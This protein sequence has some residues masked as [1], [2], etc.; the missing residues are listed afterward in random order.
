[1]KTAKQGFNFG[2]LLISSVIAL[3]L[4]SLLAAFTLDVQDDVDDDFTA[5]SLEANAS[6]DGKTGIANVSSQLPNIGKVVGAI[7]ILTLLIGGFGF[8]AQ[9]V[10]S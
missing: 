6:T 7:A 1:M 10:N 9:R 4:V 5:D 2:S 8:I 3:A